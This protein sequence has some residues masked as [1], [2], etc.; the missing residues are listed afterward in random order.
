[1]MH[2]RDL[3]NKLGTDYTEKHRLMKEKICDRKA[4]ELL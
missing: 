1:M 2:V 3:Q 4:D